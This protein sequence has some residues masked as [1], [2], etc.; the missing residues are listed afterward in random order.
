MVVVT[1]LRSGTSWAMQIIKAAGHPIMGYDF[2]PDFSHKEL[3]PNGYWD[4]PMADVVFGLKTHYKGKAV[5]LGGASLLQTDPD[6]VKKVI[7]CK[8]NEKDTIKSIVKLMTADYDLIGIDPTE[9]NAKMM[10]EINNL[11]AEKFL[12]KNDKPRLY[13][14]FEEM[15]KSVDSIKE[16][17]WQQEQ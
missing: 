17:L 10:Y 3:N 4:L 5:K 12:E 11:C 15:N 1:G 9:E 16:F 14:R 2:H 7:V 6:F 8:R 13:L